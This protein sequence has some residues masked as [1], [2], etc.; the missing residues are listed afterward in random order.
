VN[1]EI[2]YPFF[3]IEVDQMIKIFRFL[4]LDIIDDHSLEVSVRI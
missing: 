1:W 2:R 4:V 3:H